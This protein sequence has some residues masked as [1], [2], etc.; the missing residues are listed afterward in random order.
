MKLKANFYW[1]FLFCLLIRA[2]MNIHKSTRMAVLFTTTL[3]TIGGIAFVF[4]SLTNLSAQP[5]YFSLTFTKW[6]KQ[7]VSVTSTK[8][9]KPL[10]TTL[11]HFIAATCTT[12]WQS[13]PRILP[14]PALQPLGL[15]RLVSIFRTLCFPRTKCSTELHSLVR[16]PLSPK[17]WMMSFKISEW[18]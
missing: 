14:T 1:Y 6:M 3:L 12:L 5:G 9:V 17:V 16:T 11:P 8:W 13:I 15:S 2:P 10:S 18:C 4:T 7:R